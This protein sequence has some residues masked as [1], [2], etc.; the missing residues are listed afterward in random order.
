MKKI[1]LLIMAC[2]ILLVS[3]CGDKEKRHTLPKSIQTY[4]KIEFTA[5]QNSQLVA[6]REKQRNKIAKLRDDL[7]AKRKA[8]FANDEKA[9]E[10]QKKENIEKYRTAV[11]DMRIKLSEERLAYD[12]EVMNIL[13]DKQKKIY[14]KYMEQKEQEKNE[15]QKRFKKIT[16]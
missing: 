7:E 4:Q 13:T 6:I 12:N 11:N 2:S 1:L 9:T 10:A 3:G 5:E 14:K 8:L 16:E 15:R